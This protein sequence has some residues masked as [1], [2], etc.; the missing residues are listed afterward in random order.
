MPNSD[1]MPVRK[2]QFGRVKLLNSYPCTN[3]NNM[4]VSNFPKVPPMYKYSP[5]E[6]GTFVKKYTEIECQL[7]GVSIKIIINRGFFHFN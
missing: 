2:W 4:E 6:L 3:Q 7:S 1:Y 5:L